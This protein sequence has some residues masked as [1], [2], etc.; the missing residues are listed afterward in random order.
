V[1]ALERAGIDAVLV[2]AGPVGGLVGA[3]PPEV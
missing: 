2:P 3:G 1:L